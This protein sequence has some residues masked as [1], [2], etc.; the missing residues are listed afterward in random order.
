MSH[1]VFISYS[2]KDTDKA[3]AVCDELE[4][5][6]VRCWIAP[7]DIPTGGNWAGSVVD[8][9]NKCETVVLL[10]SKSSNDSPDVGREI[11]RACDHRRRI[12]NVR[13]ENILPTGALEYYLSHSQWFDA[14]EGDF[15]G[16][17]PQLAVAVQDPIEASAWLHAA[18]QSEIADESTVQNA[19]NEVSWRLAELEHNDG[20][21]RNSPI[22]NVLECVIDLTRQMSE[23]HQWEPCSRIYL[24][25]ARGL[26]RILD[27]INKSET[28]TWSAETEY[29][30][31][32]LRQLL[33]QI[34]ARPDGAEQTF[35]LLHGAFIEFLDRVPLPQAG[36][37]IHRATKMT[38][39]FF[40]AISLVSLICA[41]YPAHTTATWE[42]R[43]AYAYGQNFPRIGPYLEF[44]RSLLLML[45]AIY[46]FEV[47]FRSEFER[48]ILD[49]SR[50]SWRRPWV[51]FSRLFGVCLVAYATWTVLDH[52]LVGSPRHESAWARDYLDRINRDPDSEKPP[53]ETIVQLQIEA[54]PDFP[55]H[56]RPYRWY[57]MYCLVNYDVY[58]ALL[59]V[60][61]LYS[62]LADH[63]RLNEERDG[64]DRILVNQRLPETNLN[65]EFSR[66]FDVCFRHTQR[67]IS[68]LMCIALLLVYESVVTRPTLSKQGWRYELLTSSVVGLSTIGWVFI[69]S[70]FYEAAFQRCK[71]E[72]ERR[73]H[74]TPAWE[75]EWNTRR[76]LFKCFM[77]LRSGVALSIYVIPIVLMVTEATFH[78]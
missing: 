74:L 72:K 20:P 46:L 62:I 29:L 4:K 66:F 9:I 61:C 70:H 32:N 31:V 51:F 67:Y 22:D 7:R 2:T 65:R 75:S 50:H 56:A 69:L 25:A 63:R 39:V 60:L 77:N 10:L 1:Q 27:S 73:G 3:N 37:S 41:Y 35:R 21:L 26:S 11:N 48:L 17:L 24:T 45:A 78:H 59:V 38:M 49:W 19:I 12:V 40:L 5:N 68:L 55:D 8:A 15:A 53:A 76:F 43:Y 71:H 14:F 16:H 30:Q 42:V 28:A 58:C 47:L 34:D 23:A 33:R 64:L 54:Q 52:V 6:G 57:L 13:I 44:S 18:P 36:K